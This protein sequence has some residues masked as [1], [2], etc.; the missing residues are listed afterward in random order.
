MRRIGPLHRSMDFL[1]HE[2]PLEVLSGG[3]LSVLDFYGQ[4]LLAMLAFILLINDLAALGGSLLS[5]QLGSSR[6]QS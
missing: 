1:L 3:A 2:E 5:W 6:M 4:L